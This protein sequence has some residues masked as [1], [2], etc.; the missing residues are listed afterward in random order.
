MAENKADTPSQK[1]Q[2]P[3]TELQKNVQIIQQKKSQ[4]SD[5]Y[6]LTIEIAL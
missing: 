2:R 5:L 3:E 4:A 1:E 6:F